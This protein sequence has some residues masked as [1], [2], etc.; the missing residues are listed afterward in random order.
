MILLVPCPVCAA[1]Q[2][3]PLVADGDNMRAPDLLP[4]MNAH[5][6]SAHNEVGES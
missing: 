6:L 4:I 2:Q 5:L 1:D 3:V